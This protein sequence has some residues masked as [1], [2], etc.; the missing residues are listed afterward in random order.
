M[1]RECLDRAVQAAKDGAMT[2]VT[3]VAGSIAMGAIDPTNTMS[4]TD[5]RK[6]LSP[7]TGL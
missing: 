4:A 3:T 1:T 5:L 2:A 7:T 6:A